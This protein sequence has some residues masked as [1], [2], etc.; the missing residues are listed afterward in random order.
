MNLGRE[1]FSENNLIRHKAMAKNV[2]LM[3]TRIE[4]ARLQTNSR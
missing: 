4:E 3:L 2:Q 1:D